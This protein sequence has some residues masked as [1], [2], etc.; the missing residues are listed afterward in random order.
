MN[1]IYK[2]Q[3][4]DNLHIVFAIVT[5]QDFESL[6]ALR[7][8]AMRES[9][10]RAGKFDPARARERLKNGFKAEHARH[11]LV[12]GVHAGFFV[13][14]PV[15]QAL[16]LEHLYIHPDYQARGIGAEVMQSIIAQADALGVP[17]K[18]K[19]LTGS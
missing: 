8:A 3:V 1:S 5:K 15:E 13:L 16:S 11:I 19:A 18:V 7:I 9:L 2:T 14:R 10:E 12:N 6:V 17:I 4:E